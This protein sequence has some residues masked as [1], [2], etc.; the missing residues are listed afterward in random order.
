MSSP[1][2]MSRPS[3]STEKDVC[4]LDRILIESQRPRISAD[5]GALMNRRMLLSWLAVGLPTSKRGGCAKAGAARCSAAR[6]TLKKFETSVCQ[7]F[8]GRAAER[9]N[10]VPPSQR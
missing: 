1:K 4:A 5:S 10:W 9:P 8:E 7:W 6:E 3:P 2:P